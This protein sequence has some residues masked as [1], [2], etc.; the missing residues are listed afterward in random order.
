MFLLWLANLAIRTSSANLDV[1]IDNPTPTAKTVPGIPSC[2][3]DFFPRTPCL[4]FLYS[5]NNSSEID[6]RD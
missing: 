2:T 5:P 3:E 6:V 4:D 1:F